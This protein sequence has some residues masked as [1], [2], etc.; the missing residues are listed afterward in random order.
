MFNCS[1]IRSKLWRRESEQH[2]AGWEIDSKMQLQRIYSR[3]SCCS[4]DCTSWP[5]NIQ[6]WSSKYGRSTSLVSRVYWTSD[7]P[8]NVTD[9]PDRSRYHSLYLVG[10][11]RQAAGGSRGEVITFWL[12]WLR[13]HVVEEAEDERA[14]LNVDLTTAVLGTEFL[15]D[16]ALVTKKLLVYYVVNTGC[17]IFLVRSVIILQQKN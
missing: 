6:N 4:T 10:R 13:L 11:H 16:V 12:I 14:V 3:T 5:A 15:L 1:N 7:R 9:R 2:Q 17:P 8:V